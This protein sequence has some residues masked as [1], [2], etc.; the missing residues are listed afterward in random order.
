MTS[1]TTQWRRFQNW[2]ENLLRT[3]AIISQPTQEE[4]A[5]KP[6]QSVIA[7]FFSRP[8][9]ILTYNAGDI[10]KFDGQVLEGTAYVDES[11]IAGVSSPALISASSSQCNVLAGTLVT[12]GTLTVESEQPPKENPLQEARDSRHTIRVNLAILEQE[13]TE[14]TRIA[15][16]AQPSADVSA[17]KALLENAQNALMLEFALSNASAEQLGEILSQVFAAMRQSTQARRLLNACVQA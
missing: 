3:P 6:T 7:S 16:K 13:L 11:A 4:T 14:L 1:L 12:E 8:K 2:L 15:K 5:K 17:A 9:I 10:I